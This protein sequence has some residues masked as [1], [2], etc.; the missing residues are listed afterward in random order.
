[1]RARIR[2]AFTLSGIAS[3]LCL[4]TNCTIQTPTPSPTHASPVEPSP[5]VEPIP[6][7]PTPGPTLCIQEQYDQKEED[8][9]LTH[10]WYM[11]NGDYHKLIIATALPP[12]HSL[13]PVPWT[14]LAPRPLPPAATRTPVLPV[15]RGVSR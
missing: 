12:P 4:F 2:Q 8:G 14:T 5:T 6:L 13:A 3:L 15:A 1:M 9:S 11:C 10:V 7:S